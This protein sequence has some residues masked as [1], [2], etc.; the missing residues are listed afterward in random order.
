MQWGGSLAK[1]WFFWVQVLG[2]KLKYYIG[3]IIRYSVIVILLG[4]KLLVM[5]LWSLPVLDRELLRNWIRPEFILVSPVVSFQHASALIWKEREETWMQFL[6]I[7]CLLNSFL[8]QL[9]NRSKEAPFL[10]QRDQPAA[11]LTLSVQWLLM[12][13]QLIPFMH[14]WA[15]LEQDPEIQESVLTE[16]ALEPS[17]CQGLVHN[18][19]CRK[20]HSRTVSS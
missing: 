20:R 18:N 12:R 9:M 15:G 4:I 13:C 5:E 7:I 8:R 10:V 6:C 1:C 11:P 3:N 14:D 2:I 17:S 19:C 16:S